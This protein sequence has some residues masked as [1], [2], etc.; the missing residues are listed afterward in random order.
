VRE[1]AILKSES[2]LALIVAGLLL[3]LSSWLIVRDY[4]CSLLEGFFTCPWGYTSAGRGFPLPWVIPY[5][6]GLPSESVMVLTGI[7]L[8]GFALDLLAWVGLLFTGLLVAIRVR[9][10]GRFNDSSLLGTLLGLVCAAT[11]FLLASYLPIVLVETVIPEPYGPYVAIQIGSTF[12]LFWYCVS[13]LGVATAVVNFRRSRIRF[14]LIS[15][16]MGIFTTLSTF[17]RSRAPH[18]W[19][20]FTSGFPFRWFVQTV[21]PA[22]GVFPLGVIYARF[23]LDVVFWGLFTGFFIYL[24]HTDRARERNLSNHT[25]R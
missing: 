22:D 10:N 14:L 19:N 25:T 21:R 1:F 7:E 24:F 18:G 20:D 12:P 16:T 4:W 6:Q 11:G 23:L 13:L 8:A 9:A 3:T 2:C 15:L 5:P 17:S